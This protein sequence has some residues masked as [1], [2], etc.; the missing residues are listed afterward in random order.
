[1]SPR[2]TSLCTYLFFVLWTYW[3]Y[4]FFSVFVSVKSPTHALGGTYGVTSFITI[5]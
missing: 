1:M 2:T 5:D 4:G 3:L